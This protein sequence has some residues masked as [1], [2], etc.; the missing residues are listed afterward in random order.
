MGF[1]TRIYKKIQFDKKLTIIHLTNFIRQN[2]IK[3]NKPKGCYNI[4]KQSLSVIS[5][6]LFVFVLLVGCGGGK[7]PESNV[8]ELFMP[9]VECFEYY[10]GSAVYELERD[11]NG[12]LISYGETEDHMPLYKVV[13][14]DSY[15]Q[16]VAEYR[17]YISDDIDSVNFPMKNS[18]RETD[19]GLLVT[20]YDGGSVSFDPESIKLEKEENGKY[21]IS[22]DEYHVGGKDFDIYGDT[23][24]FITTYN[25]G[26]LHCEKIVSGF[27]E[28]KQ[29]DIKLCE[30]LLAT[31]QK[32][33]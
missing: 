18:F 21:Y 29:D 13:G 16:I 28:E 2:I 23:L 19:N 7:V 6:L 26:I 4:K 5:A 24:T 12:Q 1:Y 8:K 9:T 32:F 30:K 31:Y 33:K 10:N 20:R 15:D 11:E 17:K 3:L 27:D 14:F 25:D 22:V